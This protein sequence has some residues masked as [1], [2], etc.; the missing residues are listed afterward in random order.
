MVNTVSYLKNYVKFA[1]KVRM[2]TAKCYL[3]SIDEVE[4]QKAKIFMLRIAEELSASTEDLFYWLTAVIGRNTLSR[5]YRDIWDFLHECDTGDPEVKNTIKQVARKRTVRGLVKLVNAP[6]AIDL[7]NFLKTDE[8]VIEKLYSNLLKASKQAIHN[9]TIKKGLFVRVQNKIKHAM[10][11]QEVPSGVLIK[12]MRISPKNK[13][14]TSRPVRHW[15][16]KFFLETDK[17]MAKNL[18]GTIESNGV[19]IQ[20]LAFIVIYGLA[21]EMKKL[22]GKKLDKKDVVYLQEALKS[23]SI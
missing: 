11:V 23:Y 12:D 20:T 9:R 19:A 15:V 22:N 10:V 14:I 13:N 8:H 2:V 18:V 21:E 17:V 4:G 16:R 5:R 7:A 1:Y 3:D 6:K